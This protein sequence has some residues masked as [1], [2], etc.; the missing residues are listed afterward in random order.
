MAP[1]RTA[2]SLSIPTRQ[3]PDSIVTGSRHVASA[4]HLA[5]GCLMAEQACELARWVGRPGRPVTP[6]RVVRR[7]DVAAAETPTNHQNLV[8]RRCDYA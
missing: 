3:C 1:P 7:A 2:S 6:G 5:R 4:A 8:P